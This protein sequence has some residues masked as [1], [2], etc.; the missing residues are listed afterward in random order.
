MTAVVSH[1]SRPA[2]TTIC[3]TRGTAHGRPSIANT[4]RRPDRGAPIRLLPTVYILDGLFK[5]IMGR[6][7]AYSYK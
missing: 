6:T 5:R 7:F 4:L 2:K 3:L 1:E